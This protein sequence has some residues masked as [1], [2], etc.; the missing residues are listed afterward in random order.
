MDCSNSIESFQE[1]YQQ[2]RIEEKV[3]LVNT[4]HLFQKQSIESNYDY[5][6]DNHQSRNKKLD[7]GYNWRKYG[8]KQMKG[9]E[10]PRSYY[11]CTYRNCLV[12]KKV[13]TS[14]DGDITEIIYKG[15]H[16]HPKPQSNKRSSSYLGSNSSL[17][18][19]IGDDEFG[20]D[21]AQAKR[22]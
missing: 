5:N 3:N 20:E 1:I 10:N 22:L 14:L 11:K 8:Q 19:S 15:N 12:R 6:N 2:P 7:D 18:V 4:E 17:L 16:N 21:E 9:S 13:E